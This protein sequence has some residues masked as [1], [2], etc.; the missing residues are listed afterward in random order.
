M[1]KR[2]DQWNRGEIDSLLREGR[3]IQGRLTSSHRKNEPDSARVF[4]NLVMSGQINSALRYL[5]GENR[6]GVLP[7]TDDVMKQLREKHPGA[8]EAQLGTLVFGPTEQVHDSI[9]QQI[10]E[11]MVREAALKTKGSGGPSGVDSNGFQ[12]MMACKSFK[13]SGINLCSAIAT[14]TRRLCTEYVDPRSIEA[15]PANR[16]IP[17]NKGEGKVQPI[18][19]GEVLRQI[20]G[21]CVM[22]AIKQDM[23]DACGSLQ[24]CTGH[25]VAAR[26]QSMQWQHI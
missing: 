5:S 17:L 6:G 19:V 1:C 9:F 25:K 3:A 8:Q 11:E 24:V 2:L 4:A 22:S 16:L 15:I 7:L 26:P 13:K 18:G 20:M 23:I 14:M 12:W 10:N 21:K